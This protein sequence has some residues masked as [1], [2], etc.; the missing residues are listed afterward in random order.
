MKCS[1]CKKE[2]KNPIKKVDMAFDY[3]GTRYGVAEWDEKKVYCGWWCMMKS[4]TDVVIG[5]MKKHKE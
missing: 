3:D 1:E 2:C 4:L 5:I